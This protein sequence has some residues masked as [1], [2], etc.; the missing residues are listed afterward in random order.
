MVLLCARSGKAICIEPLRR[1]PWRFWSGGLVGLYPL[2]ASEF[3]AD[4][5]FCALR[6][7]DGL[8]ALAGK[9]GK[10]RQYRCDQ[11]AMMAVVRTEARGV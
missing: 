3:L 9:S 8:L 10:V 5:A 1:K 2:D 11:I 6:I 4:L 7:G